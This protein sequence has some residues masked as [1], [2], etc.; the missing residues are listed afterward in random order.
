MA[1]VSTGNG[2]CGGGEVVVGEVVVVLNVGVRVVSILD[3]KS[4]LSHFD[5][6]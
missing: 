4:L 5:A 2:G 3:L 6:N 1:D